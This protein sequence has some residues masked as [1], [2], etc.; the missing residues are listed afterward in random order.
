ME[1]LLNDGTENKE[2]ICTGMTKMLA[3]VLCHPEIGSAGLWLCEDKVL[4]EYY[5]PHLKSF[6]VVYDQHGVP[7]HPLTYVLSLL[8]YSKLEI[9]FFSPY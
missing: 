7:V 3:G 6:M 4:T 2:G 9:A 8:P 1:V 5:E